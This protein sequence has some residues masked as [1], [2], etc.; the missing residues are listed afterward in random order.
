MSGSVHSH[1]L[2]E[3]S[4]IKRIPTSEDG[5]AGLQMRALPIPRISIQAFC[6]T[7]P[8]ADAVRSAAEDRRLA[9]THFALHWGGVYAAVSHFTSRP[10]PNVILIES[11]LDCRNMLAVLDRLAQSCD[12]DTKVI[13]IGYI[14]DVLFYRELLKRGVSE[15]LVAPITPPQVIEAISN[16][17]N[18]L[19]E[20]P[21]GRLHAFIG[22]KG[23]VGSSTVCHNV[24]WSMSELL[25][26]AVVI[27]DLDLA[28]GTT[29]LDF[30]QD[31]V[32]GIA[33]AL[34]TPERLDD[35]L[36]DRL[37][38]PFSEHL[39][40]FAAPAALDRILDI[41]PE[42]CDIVLDVVR[43]NVPYV[44]LDLPHT[45]SSWTRQILLNADEVV[46]TAAPDLPNLRNAK[47]LLDLLRQSR[48][49]DGPPRLVLN[50]VNLPKRPEITVKDFCRS[51]DVKATAVIEFDAESFGH[52]A[53]NGQ[54]IE[55]LNRRAKAVQSFRKLAMALT[56]S[57]DVHQATKSPLAPLLEKLKIMS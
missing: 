49:H 18:N 5:I 34:A 50:M 37:L 31:P 29:A 54:M 3:T 12:S 10:T 30:N 7:A 26:K 47:N 45:W 4:E 25:A 53:N 51:L 36:L 28:F 56:H 6:E 17:Y 15:Y 52:A 33:E 13:I 40:I 39:S 42:A 41:T 38:T 19:N 8:A 43:R 44:A 48:H 1:Q 21:V 22:A 32:Q 55:G 14:N 46:I 20:A 27:A 24:A 11:M 57:K 35:V 16:I 2:K 9:K 23:G